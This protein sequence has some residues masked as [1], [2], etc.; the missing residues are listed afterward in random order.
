[1][2]SARQ[3][4]VKRERGGFFFACCFVFAF[5]SCSEAEPKK[6]TPVVVAP[7]TPAAMTTVPEEN[8][9]A[10]ER[11]IHARLQQDEIEDGQG[12]FTLT[13]KNVFPVSDKKLVVFSD[14]NDY[15]GDTFYGVALLNASG[16]VSDYHLLSP[17]SFA[18]TFNGQS[19][20]THFEN[21]TLELNYTVRYATKQGERYLDSIE[22]K[23]WND[24][25]DLA[26]PAG[27]RYGFSDVPASLTDSIVV[28]KKWK[29]SGE[30]LEEQ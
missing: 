11:P 29:V 17:D 20:E 4:K 2:R 15:F 27:N 16:E 9:P 10:L 24:H 6:E 5:G 12:D 19:V 28:M 30:K 18:K 23:Y 13:I 7:G 8:F 26:V 14:D 21:E 3:F 25:P 1:M 22:K